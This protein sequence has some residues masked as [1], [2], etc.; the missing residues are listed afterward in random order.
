MRE[1]VSTDEAVDILR[2][3]Y[4]LIFDTDTVP[5]IGVSVDHPESLHFLYDVKSRDREKPVAWLVGSLDDVCIYGSDVPGYA[6]RLASLFWP[7]ALTL[8]VKGASVIDPSLLSKDG[9]IGLRMPDDEGCLVLLHKL[10]CPIAT[11]SANLSGEADVKDVAAIDD[12]FAEGVPIMRCAYREDFAG[13]GGD[14]R[15][16]DLSGAADAHDFG[17]RDRGRDS[18]SDPYMS[19]PKVL[20]STVVDCTGASPCL[21]REGA[22]PFSDIVKALEENTGDGQCG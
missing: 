15:E 8:I 9:T 20:A 11:T 17:D 18:I 6:V 5:G 2:N 10:G 16:T 19:A 3:G 22:I 1:Y 12:A 4:P 21:K 7:G 13:E 14:S